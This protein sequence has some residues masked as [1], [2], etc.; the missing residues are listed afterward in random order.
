MER[1]ENTKKYLKEFVASNNKSKK[2][3]DI[4][5]E[6]VK[7][8]YAEKLSEVYKYQLMFRLTE[9]DYD[10]NR[11]GIYYFFT[12]NTTH[13]KYINQYN[14]ETSFLKDTKIKFVFVAG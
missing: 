5:R 7:K 13:K 6:L 11:E 8:I 10:D 12:N 9:F 14:E 3:N 1:F 2:W 4:F